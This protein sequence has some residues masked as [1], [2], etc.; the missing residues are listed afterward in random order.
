MKAIYLNLVVTFVL[1]LTFQSL[2]AQNQDSLANE[3]A[4]STKLNNQEV[5]SEVVLKDGNII[6][7]KV[8]SEY[9][10]SIIFNSVLTGNIT[11]LRSDILFIKNFTP[12]NKGSKLVYENLASRYFFS[13]SAI[14]M[15]KGEGYYQ[16]TLFSLSTFNYAISDYV[17]IG[18][19]F[20]LFSLILGTPIIIITPKISYPVSDN[21]HIGGGYL[22]ANI[23]GLENNSPGI[24]IAYGNL[25]YGSSKS[26]ISLNIGTSL[27]YKGRP[28]FTLN[29]FHQLSPKFGLMTENWFIPSWDDNYANLNI[30]GCRVIGRKNLFDFGLIRAGGS[31]ESILLPVP[32]LSYTLKF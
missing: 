4:T 6:R 15:K 28:T 9:K 3:N 13:P 20:E 23:I 31:G 8:L 25:T 5:L 10:D 2:K 24:N 21:L 16:N 19:G 12:E 27:T 29:G 11:I 7:G 32:F 30:I 18:G 22:Y 1:I 17:T 26:N 14:N